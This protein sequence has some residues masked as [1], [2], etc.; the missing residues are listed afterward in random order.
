MISSRPAAGGHRNGHGPHCAP[1]AAGAWRQGPGSPGAG[2]AA[3]NLNRAGAAAAAA[4]AA[5]R[6]RGPPGSIMTP[7]PVANV[8]RWRGRL[9][10]TAGHGP[11]P[12]PARLRRPG[13]WAA[14]P[15][16]GLVGASPGATVTVHISKVGSAYI[17]NNMLYMHLCIVLH[18]L[19]YKLHI[20]LHPCCIHDL[21]KV[22]I[23][24]IY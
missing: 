14:G 7:G 21:L 24:H 18:I 12:A 19:A 9:T 13:P 17:C 15:S 23:L 3:G 20:F 1:A 4:P 6:R 8:M 16:L 5:R 11:R 2:A 22:H 10:V